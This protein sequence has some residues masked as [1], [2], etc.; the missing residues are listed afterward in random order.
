MATRTL[1]ILPFGDEIGDKEH[2]CEGLTE[3]L[4][5]AAD[6]A[7]IQCAPRPRAAIY[8]GPKLN[9]KSVAETLQSNLIMTGVLIQ[10]GDGNI[11]LHIKL[12]GMPEN[13]VVLES[14]YAVAEAGIPQLLAQ[15]FGSL[16]QAMTLPPPA[17]LA[18][19]F[20]YG[21][22]ASA[23]AVDTYL[24][25]LQAVH[26]RNEASNSKAIELLTKAVELDSKF[27]KAFARLSGAHAKRY[28]FF[29]AHDTASL[30]GAGDAAHIAVILAPELAEAQ[31]ALGVALMLAKDFIKAG[32]AFEQAQKLDPYLY[33]AWYDHAACCFQQGLL[34]QAAALY[35]KASQVRPFDYQSVLLLRQVYLSL[36]R[37]DDATATAQRGIK[38]ASEHIKLYPDEARAYYLACGAMMQLGMYREAVEWAT[39]ALAINPEDPTINYNVACCYA[40]IGEYDKALDCLEK[41]KGFGILSPGW[42]KNDSDLFSLHGNPRFKA[43]LQSLTETKPA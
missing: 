19:Q 28:Q 29:S 38:L 16:L 12:T 37:L 32:D 22:S 6:R 41:V 20:S 13:A 10:T 34:K 18:R 3:M 2:L 11:N 7:G 14:D 17:N 42:L 26:G 21:M 4:I 15:V 39:K 1:A 31:A 27:A 24:L 43:L 23:P 9:L 40:Q 35:E 36:G 5:D 33:G 25:G 8:K 30:K